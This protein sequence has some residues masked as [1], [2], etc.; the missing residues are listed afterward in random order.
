M[1][2]VFV[3]H[4]DFSELMQLPLF[5]VEDTT[6]FYGQCSSNQLA[7][8]YGMEIFY[9]F[10]LRQKIVLV[11]IIISLFGFLRIFLLKDGYQPR[12]DG[13]NAFASDYT[14]LEHFC[15]PN[16]LPLHLKHVD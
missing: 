7:S 6:Q 1:I 4:K 3:Y 12:R 13:Y 5:E 11:I 8:V 16:V 10:Y 14:F 15:Q 9:V 2:V